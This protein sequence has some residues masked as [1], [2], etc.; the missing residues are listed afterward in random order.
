MFS[1]PF[2]FVGRTLLV[3]CAFGLGVSALLGQASSSL[4]AAP[5]AKPDR[6]VSRADAFMGYSYLAPHGTVT[7]TMNSGAVVSN[8]FSSIDLGAIGSFSYY[9][10]RYVGGQIEYA[11]GP[12]GQNDGISTAQGGLVFRYPAEGMTPFVHALAGAARVGGPNHD[13]FGPWHPY[14]WG[15]ALT[16]GGGLD[17][18]LPFM[19]HRFGLR[20]FQADYEYMHADYGPAPEIGGRAN[21]DAARLSTGILIHF[22]NIV[23]P[24]PVQ[25]ACSMNPVSVF[26]GEQVTVTGTATNL[27]P[28]KTANYNWSGQ[29]VTVGGTNPTATIDTANLQP[30]TYTVSGHVTEGNKPGQS[31]DCTAQF[32]VKQF[33]PPTVSCTANPT[34]VKP[35]E[36]STISCNGVSPQNRPLTYSY[37]A[38]AGSVNGTGNTATL[39]TTGAPSGTITVTGTVQDDKGQTAS[40]TT[41]VDVEAPPPPPA[42][43]SQTLCSIQFDKDKHRPARVDN[44]AKACL[45]DVALNAQQKADASLVVVGNSAPLPEHKGRHARNAMTADKLAAQRAVDTKDYLVTEKG[46]DASRIQVRTGTNGQNEVENYLV[47]AGANFD[48]DVPGT[49]AVDENAVKAQPRNAVHHHHHHAAAKK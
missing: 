16:V 40:A 29:G 39:S 44:E 22:G 19:D 21:I 15:P 42:P 38:S 26:P 24:P 33:E 11:N 49:T 12:N 18:D 31:A 1:R 37:S 45:D 48:N 17:Y 7:T 32:T 27:N 43:K 3:G 36:S 46:I 6:P 14:T 47:P 13:P 9:F 23:P 25:Y 8:S 20:L 34:T 28:K 5:A 30:G 41:S 10:N 4:P 35:G 2:S